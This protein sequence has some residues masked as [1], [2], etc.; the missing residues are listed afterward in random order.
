MEGY[1]SECIKGVHF[2]HGNFPKK[3]VKIIYLS[4]SEKSWRFH[5]LCNCIKF[6]IC[7]NYRG[8]FYTVWGRR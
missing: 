1:E 8:D 4:G 3:H 2:T 7:S 5:S 6:S